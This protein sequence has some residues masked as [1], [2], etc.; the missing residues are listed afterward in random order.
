M[1][2]TTEGGSGEWHTY[3]TA[4][5]MTDPG[6]I[7]EPFGNITALPSADA[8]GHE[9]LSSFYIDG[10]VHTQSQNGKTIEYSLDPDGRTREMV[11]GGATTID[12]YDAGGGGLAWTSEPGEAW[13]RDIP[14]PGGTLAATQ[15]GHG[16]TGEAVTLLVHDLQGDVVGTVE[17]SETATGLLNKYNSTEFGVPG[18]E[19]PPKY[20]W[21]GALGLTSELSSG[22][23]TQD[24]ITYVPQIGRALQTQAAE[25]PAP[26]FEGTPYVSELSAETVSEGLAGAAQ[27]VAKAEEARRVAAA[28]CNE[29]VEGCGDDPNSGENPWH[30]HVWVSW[31]H[32]TH[33]NNYLNVHG[34]WHCQIAPPDIEIQIKLLRD[35]NGKY[36][37][38]GK[39]KK[40]WPYPG[41]LGPVGSEL[42]EG[43]SCY[44]G[45]I[46]EAFV[47]GRTWNAWSNKT[48]WVGSEYDG[49]TEECDG[50]AEDPT[51]GNHAGE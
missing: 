32:G 35:V 39:W 44:E 19:A 45:S 9:L 33:L 37:L 40:V 12:H 1:K 20:G 23:V 28:G 17:D 31:G 50:L 25:L 14:G 10:Q 41:E 16:T 27:Q 26:A 38:E 48:N 29:E 34:H 18:K 46:Y 36:V 13:T 30:C 49:H 11:S 7:Y 6:V 15:K 8:G 47:W 3:D 24:G 22:A 51:T 42:I 2:C 21:L 43:E 5:R 4:D